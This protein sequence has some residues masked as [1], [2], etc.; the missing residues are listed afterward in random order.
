MDNKQQKQKIVQLINYC[1]D[2]LE[3]LND[4]DK[5][6]FNIFHVTRDDEKKE[7][8]SQEQTSVPNFSNYK[9][10]N[11]ELTKIEAVSPP[12]D[13]LQLNNNK[14]IDNSTLTQNQQGVNEKM[15]LPQNAHIR[16]RE[17]DN[18]YEIRFTINK[19]RY[20][21]FG[22]SKEA[23]FKKY[24][25]KLKEITKSISV[26]KN[27][28]KETTFHEY[29]DYWYD[30]YKLGTISE[31]SLY[32]IRLYLRVHIKPNIENLPLKKITS[33]ILQKGLNKIKSSRTRKEARLYLNSCFETA[34]IE[35]LIE[36]NPMLSVQKVKHITKK[37]KPLTLSEEKYFFNA[38]TVLPVSEQAFYKFA[39]YS[40]AR[41]GE[42]LRLKW[43]DIFLQDK[44]IHMPGTKN[45][46]SNRD[47]PLFNNLE[48][49]IKEIPKTN[50]DLLFPNMSEYKATHKFKD[51]M[52]THKL[53]DLRHTFATRC[54][55]SGVQMKTL[56]LWLGHSTFEETA[57]TYSH[58]QER[59][60]KKETDKVNKI[61]PKNDPKN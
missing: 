14:K 57:N 31:G 28:N 21:A 49:V 50:S 44:I 51:L 22:Q 11:N 37:G 58:I 15:Y 32:N 34:C 27:S 23:A 9:F 45:Q 39:I 42:L 12:S 52:P 40:G 38:L 54:L 60:N 24:K 16:K 13:D 8:K 18:R 20:S 43:S 4:E 7:A 46:T 35:N 19:L 6:R 1:T 55:E 26:Q 56:Q 17:S 59:F 53:H 47:I 3:E 33:A 36:K 2:W 41:R 48:T 61:D 10:I 30:N 25:S 5:D 29:L